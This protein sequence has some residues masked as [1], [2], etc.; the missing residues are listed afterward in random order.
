[1]PLFRKQVDAGSNPVA[2]SNAVVVERQTRYFEGVV[3]KGEGSNP[4]DRT[5]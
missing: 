4:S 1:M 2:S 5:N 3:R